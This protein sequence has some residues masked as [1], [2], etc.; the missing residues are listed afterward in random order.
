MTERLLHPSVM[1]PWKSLTH[2]FKKQQLDVTKLQELQVL[3]FSCFP[4][5]SPTK[6][7]KFGSPLKARE[8][9]IQN[10]VEYYQNSRKQKEKKRKKRANVSEGELKQG[11]PIIRPR[12]CPAI[13]LIHNPYFELI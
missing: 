3:V 6:R 8:E 5:E 7:K 13:D 9:N 11:H 4:I 2:C 12:R 1:I 10:R